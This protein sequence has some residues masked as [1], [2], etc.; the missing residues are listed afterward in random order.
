[1]QAQLRELHR[2]RQEFHQEAQENDE[3]SENRKFDM[4]KLRESE[5]ELLA[6]LLEHGH[7]QV[8]A[9]E[10]SAKRG[11]EHLAGTMHGAGGGSVQSFRGAEGAAEELREKLHHEEA[12]RHELEV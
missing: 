4:C 7:I 5:K 8:S 10:T 6:A 12:A 1:M 2:E 3:G 11:R 9:R